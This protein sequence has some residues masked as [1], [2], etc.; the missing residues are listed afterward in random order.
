VAI[1]GRQRGYDDFRLFGRAEI[2]I[3]VREAHNRIG[4]R[5][6]DP[7]GSLPFG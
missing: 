2:A 4:I 5:D 6:I 3:T 7:L 1:S